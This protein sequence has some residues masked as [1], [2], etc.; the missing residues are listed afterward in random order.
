MGGAGR[1][2]FLVGAAALAVAQVLAITTSGFAFANRAEHW[3]M[4][5]VAVVAVA[6]VVPLAA[7]LMLA[8]VTVM[9]LVAAAMLAMMML[10]A[11]LALAGRRR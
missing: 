2:L 5:F 8:V 1:W 7:G 6:V 10:L 9:L 3:A 11:V 4:A